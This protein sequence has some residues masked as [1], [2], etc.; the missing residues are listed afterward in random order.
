MPLLKGNSYHGADHEIVLDLQ[1]HAT[2]LTAEAAVRLDE[3]LRLDTRI[4]PVLPR[5]D[6][7]RPE[8]VDGVLIQRG[9]SGYG[10]S[11]RVHD[12][13]VRSVLT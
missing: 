8:R 7:V 4:Q 9:R 11:R 1:L 3:T 12:V 10:A 13:C 2:L 6:A 5:V